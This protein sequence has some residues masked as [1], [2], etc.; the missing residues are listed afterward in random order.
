[1]F[2]QVAELEV[3]DLSAVLPAIT[4]AEEEWRS[5]TI[6]RRTGRLER[7][8]VDRD[9]PRRHLAINEFPSY[10]LA[11][12]N[13]ELPETAS[14]AEIVGSMVEVRS[15]SNLDLI[16]DMRADEHQRIVSALLRIFE[17]SEVDD[18]LFAE[19]LVLDVNVP[20]ARYQMRGRAA[21]QQFLRE[22]SPDGAVVTES[23][24]VPAGDRIVG[25]VLTRQR[26]GDA[27][28]RQ[29]CVADLAC[30]QISALLIYR[31]GVLEPGSG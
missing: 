30:G 25:E 7:L 19:G 11:M 23:S 24:L 14:L 18:R 26:E 4:H 8:F 15:Y 10:E 17:S 12:Q 22:D 21:V 13:S 31:T 29:L 27:S 1:M 28:F 5:A 6:G 2:V 9:A 16:L 3:A 20:H